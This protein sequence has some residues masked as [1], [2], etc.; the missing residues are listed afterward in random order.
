M[1]KKYSQLEIK[2]VLFTD[3]DVV[4]TSQE[5]TVDGDETKYPVPG[6]WAE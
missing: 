4:R 3:E 6:G 5:G 1:M 2:I